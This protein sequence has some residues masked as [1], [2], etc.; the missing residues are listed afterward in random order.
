MCNRQTLWADAIGAIIAY[1]IEQAVRARTLRGTITEEDDGTPLITLEQIENPDTGEMQERDASVTV[2]FPS[3]LEH[4]VTASVGAIVQAATLGG[5]GILAGTLDIQD[6][7]RMLLTALGEPDVDAMLEAMY[8]P[9]EEGETEAPATE[10]RMVLA[11][12]K[13]KEAMQ[14]FVGRHGGE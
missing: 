9:D 1:V 4:D 6:V 10:A 11:A 13:L 5:A 12:Q 2:S 14:E 8:P 7:S 3:I